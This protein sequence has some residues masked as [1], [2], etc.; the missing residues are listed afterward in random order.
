MPKS[1]LTGKNRPKKVGAKV[2]GRGK[3]KSIRT[4]KVSPTKYIHVGVVPEAGPKGGHTVSG[5]V[6]TIKKKK[7]KK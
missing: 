5:P 2:P 4:V 1:K 7:R 3:I 6:H